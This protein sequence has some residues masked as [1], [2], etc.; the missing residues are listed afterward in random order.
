MQLHIEAVHEP[1]RLELIFAQFTGKATFDLAA[2]LLDALSYELVIEFIVSIHSSYSLST[3]WSVR[4]DGPNARI[5]SRT[6][7]GRR[8]PFSTTTSIG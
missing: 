5:A 6:S 8:S 1:Q 3:S 7:A 4:T 2:E